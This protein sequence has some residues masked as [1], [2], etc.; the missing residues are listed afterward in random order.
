MILIDNILLDDAV[1][2]TPFLCNTLRCKGACCTVKGGE[3]AP[4][5]DVEI[6]ALQASILPASKYLNERSKAILATHGGFEGIPGEYTTVCIDDADCVFVFYDGDVA[7]CAIEKAYYEGTT[8]FQKP[9]SCHLFPVRVGDLHGPYLYYEK[10]PECAPALTHGA[11][12]GV[13]IPETVRDA[14]I[15]A[16]GEEWYAALDKLVQESKDEAL[17][18]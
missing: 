2:S 14:L 8:D 12:L 15:R 17:M 18:N 4:L 3:G 11:E 16:Y 1:V 5:L 13:H 7:K 9:I 6:E 10:F